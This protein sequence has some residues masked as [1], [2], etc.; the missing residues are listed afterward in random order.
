MLPSFETRLI[1]TGPGD[2]DGDGTVRNIDVLSMLAYIGLV[3]GDVEYSERMD[4]SKNGAIQNIDV[5]Q[6][7]AYIGQV[8]FTP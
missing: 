7:L 1:I 8:Y 4:L 2:T 3:Q 5:L 6:A